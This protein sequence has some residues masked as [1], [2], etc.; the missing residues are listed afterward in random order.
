MTDS[1]PETQPDSQPEQQPA[2]AESSRA[3]KQR[4][5]VERVVVWGTI[6]VLVIIVVLEARAKFG[7]KKAYDSLLE[8]LQEGEKTG[9]ALAGPEVTDIL[10]GRKPDES[11]KVRGLVN[12][13][14]RVD[15]YRFGGILKK[16]TLYVYYG[17]AGTKGTSEVVAVSDREGEKYVPPPM[18]PAGAGS[19]KIEPTGQG[20]AAGQPANGSSTPTPAI[21]EDAAGTSV[22]TKAKP[23]PEKSKPAPPKAKSK[24][25]VKKSTD[26]KTSAVKKPKPVPAKTK[27][28][29]STP[30]TKKTSKKNQ[31]R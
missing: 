15:M 13:G 3:S 16:R 27:S 29:K 28:R 22:G 11:R 21:K 9:K 5:P 18:P 31:S 19:G 24:P 12:T 4:S 6:A 26:K 23:A 8:R 30:P 1:V 7:F 17:S 25:P 20:P 10:D 14:V 2:S